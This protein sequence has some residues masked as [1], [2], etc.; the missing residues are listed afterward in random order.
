MPLFLTPRRLLYLAL[1]LVGVAGFWLWYSSRIEYP[2]VMRLGSGSPGGRYAAL[3]QALEPRLSRVLAERFD[4]QLE[5][6]HTEGSVENIRRLEAGD[7]HLAFYQE[8]AAR[9]EK[10]QSVV[11]L[12]YE[13]LYWVVRADAGI[14][15]LGNLAGRRVNLGPRHS[16]TYALSRQLLDYYP[17]DSVQ[18]YH[19][20]P[21]EAVA[22]FEA[23]LDAAFFVSAFHAPAL[24]RLLQ[25]ADVRL[26]PLPFVPAMRLSHNWVAALPIPAMTFRRGGDPVPPEDV[27]TLAVKSSIVAAAALPPALVEAFVETLLETPFVYENNLLWLKDTRATGFAHSDTQFPLHAG[28]QAYFHPWE[29]TIPSDFVESWNGIV[30]MLV[31]VFSGGYTLVAHLRQ[32]R[33]ARRQQRQL[34]KKDALDI[35]IR[36][37]EEIA[38]RVSETEAADVLMGLRRQLNRVNL[39]ASADYRAE[40][41]RSSEDFS[42]FTAQASLVLAQI[43]AKIA[44]IG[45][46]Q[47][48]GGEAKAE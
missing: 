28:A 6:V 20:T 24:G 1:I 18:A 21:E 37:V 23:D 14:A 47:D 48:A 11:N 29:P 3:A 5:V 43:V 22:R 34:A 13:Y 10:V 44:E 12:E 25:T 9:S 27:P 19:Y 31:L 39:E 30:G 8:G 7:L 41:F 38:A 2:A 42:A 17:V 36:R 26:L 33:E 32:R 45:A 46:D 4:V 40:R 16:G 35:Y 15:V